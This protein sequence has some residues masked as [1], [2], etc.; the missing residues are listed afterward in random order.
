VIIQARQAV[1]DGD[2]VDDLWIETSNG[3]IVS[4]NAGTHAQPD[5]LVEEVLIPGFVDIHCHGG[6][7]HY[8]SATSPDAISTAIN[9]HKKT[10]TTS[11]VASLVTENI[12]DLKTQIQRLVPFFNRGD[13]VGIH[14]EGPFLSHARCGAHEPALLID[15]TVPLLQ[16]LIEVGQGAIKM[17]TIAPELH[18]AQDAIKFLAS[19]GV[20]AAIG[21]TEG[22]YQDAAVATD[23]G[24]SIVTHFLNAMNKEDADGSIANFVLNDSR[25]GVELIVDGHHLPYAKVQ[26]IFAAIGPR[27]LMVSDAMAAAGNGDGTYTIGALPVEVKN[28]VARLTSNQKL[29]GSTLT[30]SQAFTNLISHCGLSLQQAVHATSTQSAK[31]FGL[32]DRGSIAI[33]K[34]ADLLSYNSTLQSVTVIS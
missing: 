8:F 10:G 14:L 17:V 22:T 34:R 4:I 16:E 2:L 28:G 12:A 18:G 9:A 21:H 33:G 32:E 27:I 25:L 3:I 26:E 7:G 1:V 15:P 31:V 29:A 5:S 13:I 19:V 11:L 24:A 30:I 20:F 6:G 23:H